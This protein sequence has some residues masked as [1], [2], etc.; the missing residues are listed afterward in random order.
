MLD[1]LCELFRCLLAIISEQNASMRLREANTSQFILFYSLFIGVKIRQKKN[2]ILLWYNLILIRNSTSIV[3]IADWLLMFRF[4]F[5]SHSLFS[6]LNI[7][8]IPLFSLCCFCL[9]IE[10]MKKKFNERRLKWIA[11]QMYT[12]EHFEGRGGLI[13][14]VMVDNIPIFDSFSSNYPNYLNN[15]HHHN[16]HYH[17]DTNQQLLSLNIFEI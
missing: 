1:N 12:L 2:Q 13:L 9:F 10:K 5:L 17:N 6:L 4:Y 3:K 8:F 7:C 11:I 15:H 14:N 16:H